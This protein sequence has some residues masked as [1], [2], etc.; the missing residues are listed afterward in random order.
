MG[1]L[2]VCYKHKPI[3][4]LCLI[5]YWK[6]GRRTQCSF[7]GT[8]KGAK[9][10]LTKKGHREFDNPFPI[11]SITQPRSEFSYGR[12]DCWWLAMTYATRNQSLWCVILSQKI[13]IGGCCNATLTPSL[14]SAMDVLYWPPVR[15]EKLTRQPCEMAE[16]SPHK[17]AATCPSWRC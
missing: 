11:L 1:P 16:R 13:R 2:L 14:W 17:M 3:C 4:C 8:V 12:A 15:M 6:Q 9:I 10:M 7:I 5:Q